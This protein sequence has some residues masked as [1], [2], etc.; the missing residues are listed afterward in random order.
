M[1][2]YIFHVL[3]ILQTYILGGRAKYQ[4]LEEYSLQNNYTFPTTISLRDYGDKTLEKIRFVHIPKTGTTFAATV[5]H[6][7]CENLNNIYVDVLI[8]LNG[9]IPQPWKLDKTCRRRILLAKSRNGNWWTHIPYRSEEDKGYAVA[10]F[11]K[12]VP[13]LTSQ[14]LHMYQ[15]MGR[16]IAFTGLDYE[17]IEPIMALLK[18]PVKAFEQNRVM[19]APYKESR[20]VKTS[21]SKEERNE[22]VKQGIEEVHKVWHKCLIEQQQRLGSNNKHEKRSVQGMCKWAAAAHYPGLQGCVT[23]MI[24]GRNCCEKCPITADDMTRALSIV[25]NDF[26]F[27]GLQER[28]IDSIL[29]FHGLFGGQVYREELQTKRAN[30]RNKVKSIAI[31]AITIYNYDKH[32]NIIYKFVENLFQKR[33]NILSINR[34]GWNVSLPMI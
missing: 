22:F 17:D 11:R 9:N 19:P 33:I 20:M 24:L 6:Y 23:K 10:M 27:V 29:S 13:R 25:K 12:P 4:S 32:D 5:C 26:A 15:L 8:R 1:L 3:F 28:W 18:Y 30:I 34:I 21:C 31:K 16:M 2:Q 14:L 7:A